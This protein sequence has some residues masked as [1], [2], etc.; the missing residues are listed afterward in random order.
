[1]YNA[2][3]VF[4]IKNRKIVEDTYNGHGRI[5]LVEYPN[6]IRRLSDVEIV[7]TML[8]AINKI[9]SNRIDGIEQFVQAFIK[10]VNCEID[11]TTF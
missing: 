7:I 6:N 8:D 4:E 2:K 10:F 3:R 1:M 11:E 9:Q 5:L